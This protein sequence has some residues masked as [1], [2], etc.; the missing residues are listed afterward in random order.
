MI[1][2][3]HVYFVSIQLFIFIT[4]TLNGNFQRTTLNSDLQL[5]PD[6]SLVQH[7]GRVACATSTVAWRRST[8][9]VSSPVTLEVEPTGSD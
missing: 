8:I 2:R 6:D 5:S 7:C 3:Y 1:Q 4:H 9:H